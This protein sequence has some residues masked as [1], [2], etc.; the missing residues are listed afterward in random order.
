M[1]MVPFLLHNGTVLTRFVRSFARSHGLCP[2]EDAVPR[3]DGAF[4]S[5]QPTALALCHPFVTYFDAGE[6]G[7][8]Q[9]LIICPVA[10]F[11]TK[12]EKKPIASQIIIPK[13]YSA[14]KKKQR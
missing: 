7:G 14:K 6:V 5:S 12:T 9:D 8:F 4:L 2:S 13:M 10:A 3:L 1:I 11:D